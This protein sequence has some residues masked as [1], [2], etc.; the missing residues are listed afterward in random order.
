MFAPTPRVARLLPGWNT[1]RHTLVFCG[2]VGVSG[3]AGV[4]G[5]V[6][7]EADFLYLPL[8]LL[9]SSNSSK[10]KNKKNK[11]T[12]HICYK[13][14]IFELYIKILIC[15]GSCVIN[16]IWSIWLCTDRLDISLYQWW[17]LA[18][19]ERWLYGAG[20][21]PCQ[22]AGPPPHHPTASLATPWSIKLQRALYQH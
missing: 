3:V 13:I 22:V 6:G 1:L 12:I 16:L 5:V 2:V 8:L 10:K 9:P 21:G 19:G 20:R 18:G 7:M 4:V 11:N 14:C 17:R 15:C